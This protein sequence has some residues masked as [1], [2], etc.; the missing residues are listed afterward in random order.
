MKINRAFRDRPEVSSLILNEFKRIN[1]LLLPLKLSPDST[2]FREN[3][4]FLIFQIPLTLEAKFSLSP[5]AN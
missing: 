5:A 2:D 3:R 1:I 4:S